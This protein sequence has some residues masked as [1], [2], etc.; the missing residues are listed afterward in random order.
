M[1]IRIW[2]GYMPPGYIRLG[3]IGALAVM[4]C[5]MA[6]PLANHIYTSFSRG[7]LDDFLLFTTTGIE[8][9]SPKKRNSQPE[10]CSEHLEFSKGTFNINGF[11]T[12][13][14]SSDMH[15]LSS[16][17]AYNVTIYPCWALPPE[18]Y[19]RPLGSC[20]YFFDTKLFP[21]TSL[22]APFV[23][24][25][26]IPR[27]SVGN[28]NW[29]FCR[30]GTSDCGVV[31]EAFWLDREGVYEMSSTQLSHPLYGSMK[32]TKFIGCR[33]YVHRRNTTSGEW[34]WIALLAAHMQGDSMKG[35]VAPNMVRPP[36]DSNEC[37]E[38]EN[39]TCTCVSQC[40]NCVTEGMRAY[41]AKHTVITPPEH[42]FWFRL[43]E[44]LH[45]F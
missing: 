42:G 23:R 4:A 6:W 18:G 19:K 2:T 13:E 33:P 11:T 37:R 15:V 17:I 41:I 30:P 1:H 21:K 27:F 28:L 38:I 45:V 32:R 24:P 16:Y 39:I 14:F 7:A 31:S 3:Y 22:P 10:I 43:L 35:I 44:R 5:S 29:P 34:Q 26:Y 25:T 8:N 20:Q 40:D 12:A 9:C 36:L